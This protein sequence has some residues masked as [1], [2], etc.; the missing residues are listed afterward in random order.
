[1]LDFY[2]AINCHK[3]AFPDFIRDVIKPIFTYESLAGI[4]PDL[5]EEEEEEEEGQGDYLPPKSSA[6]DVPEHEV[7]PL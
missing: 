3:K 2:R 5:M 7:G 4:E 1:M 6:C